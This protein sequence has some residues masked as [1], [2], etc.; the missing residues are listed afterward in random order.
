VRHVLSLQHTWLCF[1]CGFINYFYDGNV[2]KKK[3]RF[4]C[5]GCLKTNFNLLHAFENRECPKPCKVSCVFDY[6]HAAANQT[7]PSSPVNEKA[8]HNDCWG[9][10]EERGPS[11]EGAVA[12]VTSST[13]QTPEPQGQLQP[14]P[15]P[16]AQYVTGDVPMEVSPF[17]Q[18]RHTPVPVAAG[19]ATAAPVVEGRPP[20]P[21][22]AQEIPQFAQYDITD[23]LDQLLSGGRGRNGFP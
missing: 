20:P 6:I 22:P 15:A 5:A 16:A 2:K 10:W 4:E 23:V 9:E 1:S 12:T 17:G 11:A 14:V 3:E 21:P 19:G 7:A 18:N 13:A 8:E